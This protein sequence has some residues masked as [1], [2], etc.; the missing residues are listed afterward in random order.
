MVQLHTNSGLRDLWSEL[1]GA[2][3]DPYAQPMRGA[4]N[5]RRWLSWLGVVAVL[6]NV[7]AGAICYLPTQARAAAG[8]VVDDVLGQLAICTSHGAQP[9]SAADP[10]SPAP[11]N[12]KKSH[13]TACTLLVTFALAVAFAYAAIAFP[14]ARIFYQRQTGARTLADHLSLG[15]IRSRAPPAFA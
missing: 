13:C 4:R 14:P 12:D 6:G 7:L 3:G 5:G 9:A 10:Q 8:A 2:S 1:T 15:G 11:A